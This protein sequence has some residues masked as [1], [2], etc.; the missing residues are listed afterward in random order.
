MYQSAESRTQYVVLGGFALILAILIFA[1][2]IRDFVM[3]IG[4]EPGRN[5]DIPGETKW[6][7]RAPT[8]D[9]QAE[10][11]EKRQQRL[12]KQREHMDNTVKG[13]VT[14]RPRKD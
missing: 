10:T 8:P 14:R 11:D 12:G 5:S 4:S 13:D 2:E 9:E 6:E 7:G 3:N 1:D